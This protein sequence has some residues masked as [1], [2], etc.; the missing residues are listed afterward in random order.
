MK[1]FFTVF[2]A[3]IQYAV[4]PL[5]HLYFCYLA[6][7]EG[8]FWK[9]LVTFTFP[10]ISEAYWLVVIWHAAGGVTMLHI[11]VFAA[12]GL[13]VLSHF[14]LLYLEGRQDGRTPKAQGYLGWCSPVAT[15]GLFGYDKQA[16]QHYLRSV[17]IPL[18]WYD[19][20]SRILL[21]IQITVAA[22]TWLSTIIRVID[23][24]Y[25]SDIV[26]L[27]LNPTMLAIAIS[28]RRRL[29]SFSAN[30]INLV[31][32]LAA[33]AILPPCLIAYF[34]LPYSDLTYLQIVGTSPLSRAIFYAL[35]LR[36][37]YKRRRIL[38]SPGKTSHQE[39]AAAQQDMPQSDEPPQFS[40]VSIPEQP[41]ISTEPKP[42]PMPEPKPEPKPE[43]MP[44]PKPK[45][46]PPSKP[47]QGKQKNALEFCRACGNPIDARTG[48]CIACGKQY[49]RLKYKA[50]A[51]A[52]N[53]LPLLGASVPILLIAF[54]FIIND[55]H[56]DLQATREELMQATEELEQKESSIARYQQTI[57]SYQDKTAAMEDEFWFFRDYAAIITENNSAYHHYFCANWDK[58][59]FMI[60]NI[61]NA[62][63]YGYYP[64]P[65]CW[66]RGF[67]TK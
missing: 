65:D 57:E 15:H 18:L 63:S 8:P 51:A 44:E 13:W 39:V 40:S 6:Y 10:V 55:M 19:S 1:K 17:N 37:L 56:S 33:L 54:L 27:A 25:V 16:Y 12:I 4:L 34:L 14:I 43:A 22:I 11:L 2:F 42:E 58:S 66:E 53:A 9:V 3:F 62:E 48:R 61:E 60:Y 38:F 59:S 24:A 50:A 47:Q 23:Y 35:N 52:R 29:L 21:P 67:Y 45:P 5:L 30:A 36:Y 64:C 49:H 41:G 32:A 26:Y 31:W 46:A 7:L 28:L 20:Y